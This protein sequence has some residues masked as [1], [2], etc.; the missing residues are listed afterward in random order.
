MRIAASVVLLAICCF[1]CSKKQNEDEKAVPPRP[2]KVAFVPPADSTVTIGQMRK[3]L[4]CNALLDSL[5]YIYRDSFAVEDPTRLTAYQR[6]FVKAQDM[7]CVVGGLTGGY[8]EYLWVLRN[9]GHPRNKHIL[10]S[11]GMSGF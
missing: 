10:D 6:E 8:K 3:W 11:L 4:R 2:A 5:S 1:T 7:L 9:A